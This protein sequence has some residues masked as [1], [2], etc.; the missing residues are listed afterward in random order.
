MDADFIKYSDAA[1][2][3][4]FSGVVL[5]AATDD[6]LSELF[7]SAHS[8]PQAPPPIPLTWLLQ[9]HESFSRGPIAD[10]G[11]GTRV[12][13]R[14]CK[15]MATTT[16]MTWYWRCRSRQLLQALHALDVEKQRAAA[17]EEAERRRAA[18]AAAEA[19]R[20]RDAEAAAAQKKV[21]DGWL[22]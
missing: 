20:R 21:C 3:H 10:Q 16:I 12:E 4:K 5:A 15:G 19:Q 6:D 9:G 7:R 2:Q 11:G 22:L 17:A 1:K 14:P 8:H 18:A 13:E